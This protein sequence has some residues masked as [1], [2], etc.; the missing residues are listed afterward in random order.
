LHH[1]KIIQKKMGKKVDLL[2]TDEVN[3][4]GY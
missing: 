4:H 3:L 1:F 2:P